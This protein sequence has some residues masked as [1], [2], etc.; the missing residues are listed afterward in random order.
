MPEL[1]E[2]IS[3]RELTERMILERLNP[4]SEHRADLRAAQMTAAIYR[5]GFASNPKA[6]I[7][8]FIPDFEGRRQRPTLEQEKAAWAAWTALCGGKVK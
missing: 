7:D 1:L 8:D 6:R 4:R 5:T 3:S 2:R